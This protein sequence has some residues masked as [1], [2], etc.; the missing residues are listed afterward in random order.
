MRVTATDEEGGVRAVELAGHP[1]FVATL[2]Q[3]ERSAFGGR[4][5]PLVRA[6]VR[7]A[8]ARAER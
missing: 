2:Y 1:F 8:A 6:F 5:H 3:P 7:A 4:A